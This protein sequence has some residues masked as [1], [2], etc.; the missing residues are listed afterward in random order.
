[1]SVPTFVVGTG[2]CGSTMLSN[3]LREHPQVLNLSEFFS[4]ITDF[5]GVREALSS[6][7][8]TGAEFCAI[9][10]AR[11]SR[12]TF[13]LE[14]RITE[15][16][17]LYPYDAPTARFSAQTGIPAILLTTLPHITDDHDSLFSVLCDEVSTWPEA[18]PGEHYKRLFG[19]LAAHFD[20]LLWVERSGASLGLVE[21]LLT[22]FPDARFVHVVRD[23]R[24]AVLSMQE[25]FGFRLGFVLGLIG[26]FLGVNPLD[27]PDRTNI[28]NVP[29]ELRPFLPETFDADAF[30]AFRVPL[31]L[32]ATFWTQQIDTGLKALQMVDDSHRMTL[33][34][35]DFFANPKQQLDNLAAF[36]G[37]TFIDD[38]WT[39]RCASTVR[40]PRSSWRDLPEDET[41]ALTEACRPGFKLLRNEGVEY[42]F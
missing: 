6:D 31:P 41:R 8:M 5:G 14:H 22:M 42:D 17:V 28:D 21:Q 40:P 37:D 2:R 20:K 19:W 25:H 10:A 7:P 13:A 27:N 23:G 34:Y 30:Q 35:E 12:K 4:F 1:M 26:Q 32:L 18:V 24:D 3:M 29:A 39:T 16:E 11:S 38:D 36:L 15:P 9:I 33:R